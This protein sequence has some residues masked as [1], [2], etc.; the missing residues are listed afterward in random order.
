MVALKTWIPACAGMTDKPAFT[1]FYFQ[2][3]ITRLLSDMHKLPSGG[4]KNRALR[5]NKGTHGTEV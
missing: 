3:Q 5:C 2:H 1:V 4:V